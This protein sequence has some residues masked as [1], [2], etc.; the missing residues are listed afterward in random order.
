MCSLKKIIRGLFYPKLRPDRTVD[1]KRKRFEGEALA[2]KK[3]AYEKA[4]ADARASPSSYCEQQS[5]AGTFTS[6]TGMS[7]DPFDP[8]S[9]S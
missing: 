7:R 3:A 5:G 8:W 1:L 2:R 6:S 9:F 4:L